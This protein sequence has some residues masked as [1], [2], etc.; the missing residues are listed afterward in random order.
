MHG[1]RPRP[2]RALWTLTLAAYL[3]FALDGC[4]SIRTRREP[5]PHAGEPASGGFRFL[6]VLKAHDRGSPDASARAVTAALFRLA[7]GE[8][9]VVFRG[10]TGDWT[11]RDLPPG[12][13]RLRVE[14]VVGGHGGWEHPRGDG[15]EDFDLRPGETL[16]ANVVLKKTPVGLIVV[17]SVTVVLLVAALV[18]LAQDGDID[19]PAA[20]DI[21]VLLPPFPAL[22]PDAVEAALSFVDIAESASEDDG[23]G[24]ITSYAP[25]DGAL[26]V[27]H[28]ASVEIVIDAP[29]DPITVDQRTFGIF[30][31]GEQIRSAIALRDHGRRLHL[32]PLVPLPSGAAVTVRLMGSRV[33][34]SSE[35]EDEEEDE[36]RPTL[37]GDYE[38]RFLVGN[39]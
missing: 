25:A 16:Q 21:P 27:A 6:A 22:S 3:P 19:L 11:V 12:R 13:Y 39:R 1:H 32:E 29:V 5:A 30:A 4:V 38:W 28:D 34:M 9:Q 37:S 20:P 17:L 23:P 15:D 2:R 7:N 33:H 24:R 26:D 8:E 31:S 10:T 36:E 14:R 18:V 35:D